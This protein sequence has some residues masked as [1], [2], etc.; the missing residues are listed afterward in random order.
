MPI[1]FIPAHD[2]TPQ[3]AVFGKVSRQADF[4]RINAAHPAVEDFDGL[5]A[6]S[7]LLA[8]RQP[9][10]QEE[11]CLKTGVSDFLFTSDDGRWCFFGALQPSRDEAGRLYPL[12]A[13][14]ILPARTVQPC[15][16][17]LAI[18][19]ELFF[20]GLREQI[21]SAVDHAVEMLAC[22]QFLDSW[23]APN[24]NAKDDIELA[25]QLLE[26]HL[27]RTPASSLQCALAEAGYPAL[28]DI[29]LAFILHAA[30][31]RRYGASLSRQTIPLPL[32]GAEGEGT[33]DQAVWLALYRAATEK[34]S[35]RAPDFIVC[36]GRRVLLVAPDRLGERDLAALWGAPSSLV[37]AP[38]ADAP[39]T[40]QERLP[41]C[42]ETAWALGRQ[43]QD[44]GDS[45]ASLFSTVKRVSVNANK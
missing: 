24:P 30:R 20:S 43:L 22:R 9:G 32:S 6:K 25:A 44:P 29:L 16:A 21:A 33:L 23:I 42:A 10:W 40:L 15:L 2:A 38:E 4:I 12:V 19:N 11:T 45:L 7:L 1:S 26:R 39:Q 8:R 37:P 28:E 3:Y 35:V 41:A 5:I 17:E 13:G 36:A 27:T 34:Q 31:I 18:A 14:I